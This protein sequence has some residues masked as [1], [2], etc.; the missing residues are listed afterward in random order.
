MKFQI[1]YPTH[2]QIQ[3][4]VSFDLVSLNPYDHYKPIERQ[5][6]QQT[7]PIYHLDAANK[8]G[9]NRQDPHAFQK[10]ILKQNQKNLN[11]LLFAINKQMD[12]NKMVI[13]KDGKYE[14]IPFPN[15]FTIE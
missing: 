7:T 4:F 14:I 8:F 5:L 11:E 6:C 2:S 3:G 15:H 10:E 9:L 12:A 1:R 13:Q